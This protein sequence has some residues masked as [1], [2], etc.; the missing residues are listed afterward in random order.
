MKDIKSTCVAG[1]I[2]LYVLTVLLSAHRTAENTGRVTIQE[3]IS[4]LGLRS[5]FK[6]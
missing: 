5:V 2:I 3:K 6:R 1:I 4:D